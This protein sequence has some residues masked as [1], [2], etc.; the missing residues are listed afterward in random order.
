MNSIGGNCGAPKDTGQ[1]RKIMIGHSVGLA[2]LVVI[3][4]TPALAVVSDSPASNQFGQQVTRTLCGDCHIVS[5]DQSRSGNSLASDLVEYMQ[6]PAITELAL[7]SYLQTSH[8]V[9]PNIRLTPEQIDD[10]VGYLLS[11][12][13][14]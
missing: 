13:A 2:A 7:R 3:I 8:P 5:R 9:M 6:E 10:V 4:S 14:K 1:G 11:L 12:K